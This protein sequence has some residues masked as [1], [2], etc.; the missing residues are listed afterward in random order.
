MVT[1]N[2]KFTAHMQMAKRKYR[3]HATMENNQFTKTSSKREKRNKI[4][5][6]K[7]KTKKM[8]LESP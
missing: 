1:T 2:Q 3:K 6:K 5:K 8:T 7:K 4:D